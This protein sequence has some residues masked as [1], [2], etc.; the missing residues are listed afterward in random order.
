MESLEEIG[1]GDADYIHVCANGW[2]RYDQVYFYEIVG[3]R[4]QQHCV[5]VPYCQHP[6]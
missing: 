2:R 1:F 5:I 4:A 6:P 3:R